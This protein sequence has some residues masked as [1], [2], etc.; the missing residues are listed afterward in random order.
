[1]SD[2]SSGIKLQYLS[3]ISKQFSIIM[4]SVSID[5]VNLHLNFGIGEHKQLYYEAILLIS[6]RHL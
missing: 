6:V 1:M 5:N 4:S 2:V 3:S